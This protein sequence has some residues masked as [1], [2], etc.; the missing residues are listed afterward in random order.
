MW[1]AHAAVG[2]LL[3]C[4]ACV[5][6]CADFDR[7]CGATTLLGAKLG[8][9][10]VSEASQRA[11][12]GHAPGVRIRSWASFRTVSLS[13]KA[14]RWPGGAAVKGYVVPQL[15]LSKDGLEEAACP[16]C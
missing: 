3:G 8:H 14:L 16:R 15:V 4:L 1:R 6:A 11:Q 9:R 5:H 2:L 10:S 7:C 12:P 13:T